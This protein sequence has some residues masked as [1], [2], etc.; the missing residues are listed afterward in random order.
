M[1]TAEYSELLLDVLT[2]LRLFREQKTASRRQV[3]RLYADLC[4]VC[5]M[6]QD[7]STEI[8]GCYQQLGSALEDQVLELA[9]MLE[10]EPPEWLLGLPPTEFMTY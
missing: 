8:H 9:A 2:Q 10:R 5:W 4:Q 6:I 3:S 1:T 7:T